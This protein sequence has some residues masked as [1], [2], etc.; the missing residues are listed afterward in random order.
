[1]TIVVSTIDTLNQYAQEV[2]NTAEA[3]L[4]LTDAGVPDDVF[5][6]SS[7][8]ALDCCPSV[9]VYVARISEAPTSPLSP[10]E[11]QALRST[12]GNVILVTYVITMTR[13][14]DVGMD[15]IP[16]AEQKHAA[17]VAVQ[18]DGWS[19]WNWIRDEILAGNIFDRCTGVHF[20]GWT[21]IPEQA[22]CVGGIMVI[23]AMIPGIPPVVTP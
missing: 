16:S 15:G 23:R 3:A 13:C 22:G 5:M 11:A 4:S 12:A 19:V 21:P 17:A 10:P 1:M 9:S 8:P 7:A 14:I 20:D 2:L 6:S 18:Q